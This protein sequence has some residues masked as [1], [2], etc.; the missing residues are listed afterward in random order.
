LFTLP[1]NEAQS[2]FGHSLV[3]FAKKMLWHKPGVK[4]VGN[5][6]IARGFARLVGARPDLV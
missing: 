1:F 3:G 4:A 2:T 5:L 6:A